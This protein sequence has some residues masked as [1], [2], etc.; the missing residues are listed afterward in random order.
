MMVTWTR[1]V[2]VEVVRT[3]GV[4]NMEPCTNGPD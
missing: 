2:T 1:M 4:L 3:D